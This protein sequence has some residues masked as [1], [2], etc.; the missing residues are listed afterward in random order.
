MKGVMPAGHKL[1]QVSS[2]EHQVN[3]QLLPGIP[4]PNVSTTAYQRRTGLQEINSHEKE[5][6]GAG[7]VLI[8]VF[9]SKN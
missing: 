3:H 6:T 7:P 1:T 5:K 8:G 4:I 2:I 9:M